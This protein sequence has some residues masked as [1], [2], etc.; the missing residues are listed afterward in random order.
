M[1]ERVKTGEAVSPLFVPIIVPNSGDVKSYSH[2][3]MS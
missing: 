3:R 2:L 1:R